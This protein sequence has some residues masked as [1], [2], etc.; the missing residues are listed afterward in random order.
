MRSAMRSELVAGVEGRGR[1]RILWACRKRKA[2]AR[3]SLVNVP[4]C[5]E[6]RRYTRGDRKYLLKENAWEGTRQSVP[7]RMV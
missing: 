5:C 6:A 3:R 7:E 2:R 4:L 1:A